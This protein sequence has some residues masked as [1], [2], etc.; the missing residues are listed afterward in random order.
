[1]RRAEAHKRGHDIA[2]GGIRN[3]ACAVLRFC[4][5]PDEPKLIPQPLD[6]RT[7]N[8]D[9]PFKR[10]IHAAFHAP[11]DGRH[12]AVA[13]GDGRVP[14]VHQKETSRAVGVLRFARRKAGLPEQRRLLVT[15][16][17][18]NGDGRAEQRGIRFAVNAA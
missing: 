12:K 15:R 1:M 17:A 18:R 9:G 6:R 11:G 4:G 5:A 7:R 10:I 16:R 14:R 13:G 2:A 8:E 3:A